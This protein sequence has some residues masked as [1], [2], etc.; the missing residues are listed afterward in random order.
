MMNGE[1]VLIVTTMKNEA[2]YIL[3][4]V[5]H[6]LALGVDN[7]LAFTNDF[8]DGTERLLARLGHMAPVQ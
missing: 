8:D 4:W 1:K 2:P 5:A 6:H 3:E 7:I